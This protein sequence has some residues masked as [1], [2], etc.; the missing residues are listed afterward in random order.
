MLCSC[1][2]IAHSCRLILRNSLLWA[3]PRFPPEDEIKFS[4]QKQ[5]AR[6][7]FV[8]TAVPI[9]LTV[10]TLLAF[11]LGSGWNTPVSVFHRVNNCL[12]IIGYFS[13]LG[14][15]RHAS[16]F[17]WV[18]LV[19]GVHYAA[20]QSLSHGRTAVMLG[21]VEANHTAHLQIAKLSCGPTT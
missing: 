15:V 10:S 8:K 5:E 2:E 6:K 7:L 19:G 13:M 14:T 1:T 17:E 3:C 18:L 20:Y 21:I 9:G 12:T 16:L 11:V 4:A